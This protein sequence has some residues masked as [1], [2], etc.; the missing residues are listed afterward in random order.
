MKSYVLFLLFLMSHF[1]SVAITKK[2]AQFKQTVNAVIQAFSN[3]D[4]VAINQLIDKKTGLYLLYREGVFDNYTHLSQ[5]TFHD[6]SFPQVMFSNAKGIQSTSLRYAKLPTYQ[7]EP[8]QWNKKGLYVDTTKTSHLLSSIC[9]SRNKLVP[10]NIE[11][12]TIAAYYLLERVSRRVVFSMNEL[13]LVFY[14][15]YLKGKWYITMV[16]HMTSDCSA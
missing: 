14:V 1:Y 16:D 11:S 13:E 10:D 9:K 8:G 2:E 4:S 5:I 15:S 3:Q 6:E 7:C 12:K